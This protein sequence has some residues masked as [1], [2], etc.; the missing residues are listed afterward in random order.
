MSK[1]KWPVGS[2]V[3]CSPRHLH[4]SPAH[5][6]FVRNYRLERHRQEVLFE[7][8][9][10]NDAEREHWR[11]NGGEI[12]T[13]KS[14]L[15]A[16]KGSGQQHQQEAYENALRTEPKC[17]PTQPLSALIREQSATYIAGSRYG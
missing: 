4:C 3:P 16:H 2:F 7:V 15:I 12:V 9:M 1:R 5:A 13:F 10:N 17:Q 8:Q 14:W 11:E 6:E